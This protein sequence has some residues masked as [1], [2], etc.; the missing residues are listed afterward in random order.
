MSGSN[1]TVTVNVGTTEASA[2]SKCPT[3]S[4]SAKPCAGS[5]LG[6]SVYVRLDYT[7]KLVIPLAIVN[8]SFPITGEGVFRCEFS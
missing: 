8:N 1:V 7:S 4:D 6:S 5:A 2:V 3:G